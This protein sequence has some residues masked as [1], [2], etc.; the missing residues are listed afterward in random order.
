MRCLSY[1]MPV[2]PLI[3]ASSACVQK[4][5][6]MS[7]PTI[8]SLDIIADESI[9][10]IVEQEEEIF[11]RTYKHANLDITY[12]PEFDMYKRFMS[13][14]IRMII[15]TRT[16]TNDELEY[17][18]QR[19]SHPVTTE[20]ATGALA[21]ITNK[22]NRDTTFTYEGI[23]EMMR[24]SSEGKLFVIENAKSG[25]SREIMALLK[26]PSLPPHFY[27]FQS[28]QE[29]V[30]YLE[31]HD[32][33]IGIVDWSEIS[34]SDNPGAQKML[35]EVDLVGISRPLDSI[36]YG[37]VKPYQYNLQDDKYPFTRDLY[38]ISRTGKNDVGSGFASFVAGDIGQR[39]ILKSGL[40][41]KFQS[42]R[43]LEIRTTSEIEVVK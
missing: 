42:E 16:L 33:A 34:D 31:G 15:T 21:F 37:F 35:E 9:R 5:E 4:P 36:Q 40:L 19:Q 25:I 43:I 41:P 8:G 13:D 6:Q 20:F 30:D 29:V 2:I 7:G 38:M 39:I 12:M 10:Y 24:D 23:M 11:E 32:N 14:S 27:A 18:D 22:N 3:L 17:F 28:K 1:I 26:T